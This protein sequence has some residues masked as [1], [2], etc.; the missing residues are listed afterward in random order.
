MNKFF[1]AIVKYLGDWRNWLV[2][3]L[4]GVA[5]L[6]AIIWVPIAWWIKLIVLAV[7]IA[8]NGVRMVISSKKKEQKQA[9]EKAVLNEVVLEKE[10]AKEDEVIVQ[11]E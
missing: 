10:E 1:S 2:H 8:L 4:V 5:L 11:V 6:V 3:G 7:V 9:E